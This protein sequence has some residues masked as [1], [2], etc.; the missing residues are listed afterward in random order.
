MDQSTIENI[1]NYT[2]SIELTGTQQNSMFIQCPFIPDLVEV[3][4]AMNVRFETDDQQVIAPLYGEESKNE[5]VH[6]HGA[7]IFELKSDILPSDTL[8]ICNALN[9]YNP[10]YKFTNTGRQSFNQTYNF[11]VF[12]TTRDELVTS[13]NTIV[14]LTFT[15]YKTR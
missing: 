5:K 8:C 2:F 1:Y 10:V 6:L 11:S 3:Q 4:M 12:N 9:D 7:N 14:H 15:R 13:A